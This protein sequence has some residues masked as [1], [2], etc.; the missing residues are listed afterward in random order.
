M[1][2][3]CCGVRAGLLF[4][5]AGALAGASTADAPLPVLPQL[6]AGEVAERERDL[7]NN[8]V[9][10]LLLG[11]LAPEPAA[12]RLRQQVFVL[13]KEQRQTAT[14]ADLDLLALRLARALPASAH[15][16]A[17]IGEVLGPPQQIARQVLYRRHIEQ[18]VYDQPVPLC[19][20]FDCLKGQEPA[21]RRVHPLISGRP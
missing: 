15:S 21:V 3:A 8:P 4:I 17:A 16:A 14:K 18:W 1:P 7:A 9:G 10:L 19:V 2:G 11:A 6:S 5:V 20:V 12:R 13:L